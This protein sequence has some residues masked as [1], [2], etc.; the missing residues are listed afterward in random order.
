MLGSTPPWAIVTPYSSLF[1]SL[2]LQSQIESRPRLPYGELEVPGDDAGLLVVTAGIP[3]ELEDLRGAVLHHGSHV[4]GSTGAYAL[5][6]VPLP[7]QS[8]VSS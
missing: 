7:A 3:G 4:D 5:G 8:E 2:S 6:V 1:S